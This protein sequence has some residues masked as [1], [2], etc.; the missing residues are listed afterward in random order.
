MLIWE[1][2]WLIAEM[3]LQTPGREW[4]PPPPA[5]GQPE[6]GRVFAAAALTLLALIGIIAIGALLRAH[7]SNACWALHRTTC[8]SQLR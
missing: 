5:A 2:I 1:W 4:L 3:F 8:L 6:K 7:L